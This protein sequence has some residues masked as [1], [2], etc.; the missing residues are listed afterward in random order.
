MTESS[1]SGNGEPL[2]RII[3][4]HKRFG[5]TEVLKG[6]TLEVQAGAKIALIGPSGSGKTTLLRCVNHLEKPTSGEVRL[7]GERIG[8]KLVNGRYVEMKDSG[9][10]RMR[11]SVG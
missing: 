2:V 1:D 8:G 4:L 9:I 7:A 11:A 10:A 3:D 5:S 6:V